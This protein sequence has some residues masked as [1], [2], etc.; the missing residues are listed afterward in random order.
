MRSLQ[1]K[2]KREKET[3]NGDHASLAVIGTAYENKQQ[4]FHAELFDS[5]NLH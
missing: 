4:V 5:G 3:E 1:E 2:E